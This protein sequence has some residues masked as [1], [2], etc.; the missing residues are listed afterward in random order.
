[1]DGK[2]FPKLPVGV[3]RGFARPTMAEVLSQNNVPLWMVRLTG[4]LWHY[5]NGA[6]FGIAHAI[7]FGKGPLIFT[8]GFGLLLAIVFLMIIRFL[9]PP[10]KLGVTLP[11][12]VLLAHLAVIV[13]IIVVTQTYVTAAGDGASMLQSIFGR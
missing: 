2:G 4:Y 9:I 10:M 5:S 12:V 11:V 7:L 3:I 13:V 1:M 8:V 6:S